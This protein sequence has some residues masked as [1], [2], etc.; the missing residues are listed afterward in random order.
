LQYFFDLNFKVN[1]FAEI[2]L[3][4][5]SPKVRYYSVRFSD[6]DLTEFG[7][8]VM[9]H[10]DLIEIKDEYNDLMSWIKVRLGIQKGAKE[11]F[12]RPEGAANAL[13]PPHQWL[14]VDYNENL[15]VY[16]YRISDHVVFLFNGGVKTK[17]SR[18]AQECKVIKPHFDSANKIVRAID[19]AFQSKDICLSEDQKELIISPNFELEI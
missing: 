13:P 8:F 7:R 16:C 11:G 9:K 3:V 4:F 2:K 19:R 5:E 14:D 12:F 15:R 1:T 18:T 10:K 6:K 17:K